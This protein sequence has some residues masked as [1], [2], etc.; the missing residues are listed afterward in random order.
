[1]IVSMIVGG[2]GPACRDDSLGARLPFTLARACAAF[3]AT[4]RLIV[5]AAIIVGIAVPFTGWLAI[6]GA[7]RLRLSIKTAKRE[8]KNAEQKCGWLPHS[9]LACKWCLTTP[10]VRSV[11]IRS[12]SLIR[13]EPASKPAWKN[14]VPKCLV[15]GND[16]HMRVREP[17]APANLQAIRI[18]MRINLLCLG[19]STSPC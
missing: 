9:R 3:I 4:D 1:M 5:E 7:G 15:G 6:S 17:V 13:A 14:L 18:L 2:A 11:A 19:L 10:I 16:S 12:M 8:Q